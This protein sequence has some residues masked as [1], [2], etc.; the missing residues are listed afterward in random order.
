MCEEYPWPALFK[1]GAITTVASQATYELPADFSHYHYDTW[2]NQSDSWR[3]YGPLSPQEYADIQG[4]GLTDLA[5]DTFQIRGMTDSQLTIVP[6][7]AASGDIIIF[8]YAA[9]RY[10]KPRTWEAGQTVAAGDYCF[11]NGVYYTASSA[12][13]TAGSAPASDS[14]VTW[15]VYSGA[16]ETFL[17]DTD[18]PVLSAKVFEYGVF[19]RFAEIKSLTFA[20]RYSDE[21]DKE[22]GKADPGKILRTDGGGATS[23][24]YG[25]NG[26]VVFGSGR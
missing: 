24:Q 13:T 6:T 21:L 4:F 16:Y 10:A 1:A 26:R 2:W 7:P 19:E 17:A 11:Y 15:A 14:G 22:F 5:E 8:E 18:E 23:Y 3:M 9:K 25:Q 20:E 12:G